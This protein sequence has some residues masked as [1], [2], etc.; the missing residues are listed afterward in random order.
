MWDGKNL[1]AS[2]F[3][4]KVKRK[5][6]A[7]ENNIDVVLQSRQKHQTQT[8]LARF[9]RFEHE[10]DLVLPQFCR[11]LLRQSVVYSIVNVRNVVIVNNRTG[12]LSEALSSR[13]PMHC[14]VSHVGR[15]H[16]SCSTVCERF[17]FFLSNRQAELTQKCVN[18]KC[19]KAVTISQI[20]CG[21]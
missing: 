16:V 11:F 2:A 14:V 5:G 3:K 1:R 6:Q 8:G 12:A 4:K 7:T 9:L 18:H 13:A 10:Y 15:S 19:D 21:F 20:R 17:W